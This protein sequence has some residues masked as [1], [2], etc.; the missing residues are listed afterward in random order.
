ML[1]LTRRIGETLVIGEEVKMTVLG[2]KGNQVR[3]GINAPREISIHREEIYRRMRTGLDG[4]PMPSYSDAIDAG[5]IVGPRIYPSAAFIGPRG[6][7]SDFQPFTGQPG[8]PN[9][10]AFL[11]RKAYKVIWL[12]PLMG[13]RDYEPICRGMSAAL[14]YVD[15]FLPMGNL[16]DLGAISQTLKKVMG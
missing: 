13:T 4:T 2:V 9:Q 5:L 7:H 1:N 12:N 6:G 15:Y 11:K 14:P 10:M 3:V 16:K 8:S